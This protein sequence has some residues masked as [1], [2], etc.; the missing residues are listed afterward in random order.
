MATAVTIMKTYVE[1]NLNWLLPFK[2]S[3]R[4]IPNALI[5]MTETD[6]TV[7]QMDKYIRGFF[8]PYFG[9]TL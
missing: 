7:E 4:A 9:A 8:L 2:V 3:L 5:D 1:G 6:P